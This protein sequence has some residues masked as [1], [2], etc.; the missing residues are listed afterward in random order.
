VSATG[1]R[2]P[3][4]ADLQRLEGASRRVFRAFSP[5][6]SPFTDAVPERATAEVTMASEAVF[7]SDSGR[8]GLISDEDFRGSRAREML[9]SF[10]KVGSA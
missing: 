7:L 8:W 1:I 9:D 3:T 10:P 4:G 5:Y 6:D 2:R